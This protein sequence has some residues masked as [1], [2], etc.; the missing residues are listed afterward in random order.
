MTFAFRH[1]P[2]LVLWLLLA[3][4]HVLS[5]FAMAGEPLRT[6]DGKYSISTIRITVVYFVPRDRTP[7]PD[8][9]ERVQYFCRRV[10]QFHAREFQGQSQLTTAIQE[11]PFVSDKDSAALRAGDADYIFFQ[12]LGE[13]QSRLGFTRG[14][15]ETFPI[16]L[17]LSD[18]NWR[19][20][21]DF[22]RLRQADGQFEG[23]IIDDRHFPGAASGGARSL[24]WPDRGVG[25]GLVSGDGWRVPYSGTD[26]V[27]YHE[28]VGHPIG[29][30]HP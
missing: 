29:L 13:V 18:I 10:E 25:W 30:P 3:L 12:T 15:D 14:A 1:A 22:W 5:P 24:Y 21:D 9:R 8:W 27:V 20:L 11:Q 6:Y 4:A 7:L 2:W 16:L 23:Q 28:G 19:E 17:V 26:C